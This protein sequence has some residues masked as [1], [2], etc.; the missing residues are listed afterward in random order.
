ML[1]AFR[2]R[3]KTQGESSHNTDAKRKFMTV[4]YL[5][6]EDGALEAVVPEHCMCGGDGRAC[7]IWRHAYRARQQGPDHRLL[8]ARCTTHGVYFTLYPPG[9]TPW[10]RKPVVAASADETLFSAARDAASGLLWPRHQGREQSDGEV[11]RTQ[12]RDIEN[13]ARWLG[14]RETR[15]LE[16]AIFE[17]LG[18]E[19]LDAHQSARRMWAQ[20]TGRQPRA[21]LVVDILDELDGADRLLE[22]LL[23]AGTATQHFDVVYI[24]DK[25]GGL[26]RLPSLGRKA[27]NAA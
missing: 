10:G 19:S 5:E 22:R 12:S 2:L 14:L 24:V 7:R 18:L 3:C 6:G 11:A 15:D 27:Q 25:N 13:A 17:A 20:A 4:R 9:W 16:D 1:L 23:E 26:R 21:R 8:V